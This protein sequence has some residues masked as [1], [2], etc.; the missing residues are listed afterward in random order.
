MVGGEGAVT[1]AINAARIDRINAE[2]RKLRF[3]RALLTILAFPLYTLGWLAGAAVK[4]A[5]WV[6]IAVKV[7]WQDARTT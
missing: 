7:G 5:F 4:V 2:V 6:L 3:D 1:L